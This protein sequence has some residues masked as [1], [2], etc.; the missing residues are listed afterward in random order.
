MG[1][2]QVPSY[3][4][5]YKFLHCSDNWRYMVLYSAP[6][7]C[8]VRH[9]KQSHATMYCGYLYPVYSLFFW[10]VLLKKH[11]MPFRIKRFSE[12]EGFS[13]DEL[14]FACIEC[15]ETSLLMITMKRW[16]KVK[17]RLS[18]GWHELNIFWIVSQFWMM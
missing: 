11:E 13:Y 12:Q 7:F 17:C 9:L 15:V 8:P 10:F 4:S 2:D 18:A 1:F 6:F 14:G 3:F 16:M 5:L